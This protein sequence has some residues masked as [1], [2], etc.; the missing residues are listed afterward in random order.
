MTSLTDA[1]VPP[2]LLLFLFHCLPVH[3]YLRH[4]QLL[5]RGLDGLWG[6]ETRRTDGGS[7]CR[8]RC[9]FTLL[10]GCWWDRGSGGHGPQAGTAPGGGEGGALAPAF[11]HRACWRLP[12]VCVKKGGEGRRSVRGAGRRRWTMERGTSAGGRDKAGQQEAMM[13]CSC[14]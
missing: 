10:V 14:L 3:A 5:G 11:L 2:S 6:D 12:A 1:T 7:T 9:P 4:L 13:M 8:R